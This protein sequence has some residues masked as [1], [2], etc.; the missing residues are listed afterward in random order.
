MTGTHVRTGGCLC[1]AVRFEVRGEPQKVIHCHCTM[2]RKHSGAAFL[3]YALFDASDVHFTGSEPV[4]YHS[5][6]Q[7]RRTHCGTCGSPVSF[8]YANE[9]HA[10]YLAAGA[11][12]DAASLVP[13]EH[14]FIGSRLPWTHLDDGLPQF[15]QASP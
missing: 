6:E 8:V 2:C 9:P 5:S 3:T 4:A 10:L 15:A 11:F 7:G 1:G 14:W 13:T 12:D